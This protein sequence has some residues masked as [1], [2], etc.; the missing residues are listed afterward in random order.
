MQDMPVS[1]HEKEKNLEVV[2][3]DLL[4]SLRLDRM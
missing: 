2:H 1:V 3:P 4:G